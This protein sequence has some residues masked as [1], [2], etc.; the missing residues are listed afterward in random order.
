MRVMKF[1]LVAHIKRQIE[2]SHQTFGPGPRTKGVLDHI[3]KEMIEIE[4][5]PLDL[6]EWVDVIIL[7]ID[8]AWRAGYTAEQIV[9]ALHAKQ[10]ENESR[11]WPDWR[12]ADTDKAIEHIRD[13]RLMSGEEWVG[14]SVDERREMIKQ[15]KP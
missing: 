2:F 7:G 8:G 14:M 11:H 9:Q 5:H 10:S 1:D 15:M 13:P 12:T 3:K 4:E 6:K